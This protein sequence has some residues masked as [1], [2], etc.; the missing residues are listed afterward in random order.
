MENWEGDCTYVS[1]ILTLLVC[2]LK[3][4]LPDVFC[5]HCVD[6][7]LLNFLRYPRWSMGWNLLIQHWRMDLWIGKCLTWSAAKYFIKTCN[8]TTNPTCGALH[9]FPMVAKPR[10][11][12]TGRWRSTSPL[13]WKRNNMK[14]PYCIG[15][16]GSGAW[17]KTFDSLDHID[18][19]PLNTF[20]FQALKGHEKPPKHPRARCCKLRH[21]AIGLKHSD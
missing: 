14:Q 11:E 5:S 20:A 7:F 19:L 21:F 18:N 2:F 17:V 4:I 9:G 13:P 16:A 15:V 8:Q 3:S 6:A 10:L 12:C 1:D